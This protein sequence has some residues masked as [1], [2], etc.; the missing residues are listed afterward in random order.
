ML[1]SMQ[2]H[3]IGAAARWFANQ[4]FSGA[5]RPNEDDGPGAFELMPWRWLPPLQGPSG[6]VGP[7]GPPGPAG[8]SG[9]T[10]SQG[11]PGAP[12]LQGPKGDTGST[13]LQGPKGDTG[14]TGLQGPAGAP[15]KVIQTKFL[16]Q[17]ADISVNSTGFTNLFQ[18]P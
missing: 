2:A 18:Q 8:P 1:P 14:S 11:P 15:G 12:G 3:G 4:R 6:G 17:T 7:P 13:G 9:P 10:G 16:E 5:A